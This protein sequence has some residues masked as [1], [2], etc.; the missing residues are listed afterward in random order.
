MEKM[1]VLDG[2]PRESRSFLA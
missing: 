1:A 2:G